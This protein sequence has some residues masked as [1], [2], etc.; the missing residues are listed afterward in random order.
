MPRRFAKL[1]A[2]LESTDEGLVF[3]P[4][5]FQVNGTTTPDNL[6]G[7]CLAEVTRSEAGEFLCTLRD[8]PAECFAIIPELSNTADDV[9]M[10]AKAD[11]SDVTDDGTF[12]VRTMTGAT[13]TDPTNDTF[14]G[15]VIVAKK[16]TRR[17][18]RA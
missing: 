6:K 9:D 7:D 11:W 4:F 17:A 8:L 3:I 15:G 12:T 13:Q 10:Y 5:G 18:H 1:F 16:T 14:I 2:E